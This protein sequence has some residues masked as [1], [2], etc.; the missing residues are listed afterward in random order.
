M[1]MSRETVSTRVRQI[2]ELAQHMPDAILTTLARHIDIDWLKEAYRRT[3]KDGA[4]GIDGQTALDYGRDLEA[5]LSLLLNRFK[6]GRYK[7]PPVRRKYIPK[8]RHGER[9]IGIPTFEDKVLQRAVY[10]VLEPVYEHDFYECSYGFRPCRSAHQ[11]L[12]SLWR[13]VMGMG[14]CWILEVDIRQYFDSIR[15]SYIHEFIKRRVNDGVICR[16]LGKWLK[17]GVLYEGRLSFPEAGTPQGGVISPLISNIYLHEVLDKWFECEIKPRIA[18]PATL[19]RFADDFVIIVKH[20][21][22]AERIRDVLWKRFSRFGLNLHPEKTRLIRFHRPASGTKKGAT[23][24]FLGFAHYWGKSRRGKWVVKRKTGQ[25]RLQRSIQKVYD[26][27]KTHRHQKVRDQWRTLSRKVQGHYGYFGITFNSRSIGLYYEQVKRAWQKW[28][29]RRSRRRDLS[30]ERFN[31]LLE[32]WPLP[33]PRIV[34]SFV[35]VK[36]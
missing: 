23:F 13:T 28:L 27:C 10:M 21:R 3:R 7:A 8:G 35:G 2:A 15:H 4:T 32:R 1:T 29:N 33:Q 9:P 5:N 16:V 18:G 12:E 17:S 22:T 24:S 11:A 25:D 31:R 20:Q 36:P 19:I 34:H 6:S 30:W 26:W 14:D